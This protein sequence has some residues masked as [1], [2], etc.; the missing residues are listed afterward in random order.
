MFKR[1]KINRKDDLVSVDR[2]LSVGTIS[3]Q[4]SSGLNFV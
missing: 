1:T 3:L 4:L 2:F